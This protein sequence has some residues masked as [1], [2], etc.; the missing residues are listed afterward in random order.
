MCIRIVERRYV[1]LFH[2]L[3]SGWKMGNKC[4]GRSQHCIERGCI[5]VGR[6]D[7]LEGGSET[8]LLLLA[9][10]KLTIMW[11]FLL[12]PSIW[13]CFII[14]WNETLS[15]AIA[16]V[17][18]LSFTKSSPTNFT[19]PFSIS[20]FP[21]NDRVAPEIKYGWSSTGSCRRG[22]RSTYFIIL[23]PD[24]EKCKQ[25]S[26]PVFFRG[27]RIN[28]I[29]LISFVELSL[30]CPRFKQFFWNFHSVCVRGQRTIGEAVIR[31][32]LPPGGTKKFIVHPGRPST[33]GS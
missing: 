28:K 27:Q 13:L 26:T 16:Y 8:F 21:I 32:S 23:C 24:T 11:L 30:V 10:G 31:E 7:F 9:C 4:V 20:I 29:C 25:K 5:R 6:N 2:G 1:S 3:E 15:T 14:Y 19:I 33:H 17:V 18:H 12:K 22:G